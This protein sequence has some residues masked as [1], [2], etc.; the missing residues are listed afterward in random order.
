MRGALPL[1]DSQN[2]EHHIPTLIISRESQGTQAYLEI[3]LRHRGVSWLGTDNLWYNDLG[4]ATGLGAIPARNS[5]F[6]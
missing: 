4:E 5:C 2:N 3:C 6:I 1:S